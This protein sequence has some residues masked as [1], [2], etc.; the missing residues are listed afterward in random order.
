MAGSLPPFEILVITD[1]KIGLRFLNDAFD[2]ASP[3]TPT[4][5]ASGRGFFNHNFHYGPTGDSFELLDDQTVQPIE[6]AT[7]IDGH[8]GYQHPR[9]AGHTQHN[10][11]RTLG[12]DRIAELS[13]SRTVQPLGMVTSTAHFMAVVGMTIS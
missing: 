7:Q 4:P 13:F 6:T 10:A 11:R 12:K 1:E 3:P 8:G 2:P 5:P 9:G